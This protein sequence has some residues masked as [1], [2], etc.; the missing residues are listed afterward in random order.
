MKI[1]PQL[2]KLLH[3]HIAKVV[4]LILVMFL[5]IFKVVKAN[6]K[7]QSPCL[8][9]NKQLNQPCDQIL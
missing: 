6:F 4:I 9:T 7:D 8:E 1:N 2:L 3:T 5:I